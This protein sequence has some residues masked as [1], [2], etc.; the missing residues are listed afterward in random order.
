MGVIHKPLE[1]VEDNF[2][3]PTGFAGRMIGHLMTVQH[4]TL[5]DWTIE[6]MRIGATDDI[7]DVGC[8]SG[9]AVGLMAAK[10]QR[11][12]VTGLDY[13]PEMV[14]L[15][16]RRNRAAV[17]AGQVRVLRGDAMAL[18]FPDASF[19]HVSAIETF[20]FWPDAMNGLA[21]AYRV[22]RPGGQMVV[23][24]EMSREASG[25]PSLVQRYF[26]KRFTERSAREGLRIV[27]GA[28]LTEMLTQA[29]FHDAAFI[30]EPTRSLGW[31]CAT[32][33][34]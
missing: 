19:D 3:K 28:D 12:T 14:A 29:G 31:V 21:Q 20:Y 33:R 8:G 7:L 6:R 18:P 16:T 34:R 1:L 4:R 17:Q 30:A 27:S 24:L 22:L 26:G 5:T 25:T 15:A 32:A 13:S 11:G 10:A 23:T 2:K 9:M